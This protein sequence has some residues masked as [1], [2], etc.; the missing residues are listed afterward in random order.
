[1]FFFRFLKL[2][3]H[4]FHNSSNIDQMVPVRFFTP[5]VCFVGVFDTSGD[6]D[7]TVELVKQLPQGI[8]EKKSL[9]LLIK[10]A[11]NLTAHIYTQVGLARTS[12]G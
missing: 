3:S 6:L 11:S 9:V 4:F 5:C 1:M 2:F 12:R 7:T 10:Q 8:L